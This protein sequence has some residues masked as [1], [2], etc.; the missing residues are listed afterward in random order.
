MCYS[1]LPPE[2]WHYFNPPNLKSGDSFSFSCTS[3]LRC[4]IWTPSTSNTVSWQLFLTCTPNSAG[5]HWA[6]P[7]KGDVQYDGQELLQKK[8]RVQCFMWAIASTVF[9]HFALSPLTCQHITFLIDIW[10]FY[11]SLSLMLDADSLPRFNKL[12][13]KN[14]KINKDD[15]ISALKH[16]SLGS[17]RL[18]RFFIIF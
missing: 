15:M 18:L 8:L 5:L 7:K 4:E 3:I 13:D 6:T 9:D 16:N 1:P 11:R 2:C 14:L 17:R 12:R 10:R